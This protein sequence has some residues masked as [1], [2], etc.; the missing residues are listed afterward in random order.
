VSDAVSTHEAPRARAIAG[1]AIEPLLRRAEEL[2]R[3]WAVAL[4]MQRPLRDMGAISLQ[5]LGRD[6]P[7][8]CAQAIRA[9]QSE[10]ELE[11]LGEVGASAA[12]GQASPVRSLA[13]LAGT[14]DARELVQAVE[15][16]RGVLWEALLEEIRVTFGATGSRELLEAGDRLAY[17]C[18]QMLIAA[19]VDAAEH[20]AEPGAEQALPGRGRGGREHAAERAAAVVVDERAEDR[21][22]LSRAGGERAAADAGERAPE[23]APMGG[24]ERAAPRAGSGAQEHAAGRSLPPARAV[25]RDERTAAGARSGAQEH[26]AGHSPPPGRAVLHDE[27]AAASPSGAAAPAGEAAWAQPRATSASPEEIAIRDA[28]GDQG[29]AAWIGSIGRQLERLREDGLSFA[30][31]LVEPLELER[32]RGVEPATEMLRLADEVE[33]ALAVALR[34]VPRREGGERAAGPAAAPWSDSLTRERPGR[35]WL[36]APET[37]RIGAERLAERLGR[38]VASLVEHRGAAVEVAIGIAVCPQDGADA[39]ALAA[40]ADLGLY[41]ARS[42]RSRASGRRPPT[43]RLG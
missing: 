13:R 2:A 20:E 10:V 30:V 42:T 32:L 28:R 9:V 15:A 27:R 36:L 41:A 34:L 12:R 16:L 33:D 4:I 14:A 17:V 37:D 11:R 8:L 7:S 38:A 35:Y 21:A 6:A 39:A 19:L 1:L 26:A 18:A 29:P 23:R 43:T 31:L 25:L 22:A 40:H 24:G 5:E 3:R